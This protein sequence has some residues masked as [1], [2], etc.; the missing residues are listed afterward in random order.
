MC[1]CVR[2]RARVCGICVCVH[3]V[4]ETEFDEQA[5]FSQEWLHRITSGRRLWYLLGSQHHVFPSVVIGG[6]PDELTEV[7]L[8]TSAGGK[9]RFT[10]VAE[11]TCKSYRLT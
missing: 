11:I 7:V 9:L 4:K 5:S 2:A 8:C 1:V 10:Q 6:V 3:R